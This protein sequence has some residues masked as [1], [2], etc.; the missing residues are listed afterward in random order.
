[1]KGAE[2]NNSLQEEK[3][4]LIR[5]ETLNFQFLNICGIYSQKCQ[6]ECETSYGGE[7]N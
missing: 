4:K 3:E 6:E 2:S 7:C 1:M 5:L